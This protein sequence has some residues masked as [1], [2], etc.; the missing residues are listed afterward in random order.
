M[1]LLATILMITLLYGCGKTEQQKKN[2][3][4]RACNKIAATVSLKTIER[5]NIIEVARKEMGELP[6]S[7]SV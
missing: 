5:Y 6:F 2:I 4:S 7:G 3:A 1:R